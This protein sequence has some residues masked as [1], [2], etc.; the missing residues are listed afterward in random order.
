MAL[1]NKK[2]ATATAPTTTEEAQVTKPL[3]GTS[4]KK[5]AVR[6]AAQQLIADGEQIFE[7]MDDEAKAKLGSMSGTLHF[8]HM[9]GLASKKSSRQVNNQAVKCSTHVG[10]A[11]VSDVDIKVPKIDINLNTKTGINY[12]TDVEWVDAKAGEEIHLTMF[13]IMFLV[14][15]DQYAGA[16]EAD[17]SDTGIRFVAKAQNYFKSKSKLPTPT[18]IKA[19]GTGSIKENMV[20]ID[21]KGDDGKWF[22]TEPYAEKFGA[23]ITARTVSR[24]SGNK[25]QEPATKM[26]AL[27]L[28][29]IVGMNKK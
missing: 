20:D 28:Q 5:G 2:Q 9:L 18:L 15:Q 3:A 25:A 8:K 14:I 27:A 16:F 23:L 13:E 22:I 12:E 21:A 11:V 4:A 19:S 26:V 24:S 1:T 10:V 17:G 7:K 6:E 29:N